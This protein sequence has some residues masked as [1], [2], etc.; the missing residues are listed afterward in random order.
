MTHIPLS[1]YLV[2]HCWCVPGPPSRK[3]RHVDVLYRLYI[4]KT[5]N[6]LMR[7]VIN[8]FS[9]GEVTKHFLEIAQ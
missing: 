3:N 7:K 9:T 2:Q 6:E 8:P 1:T 4:S 5:A